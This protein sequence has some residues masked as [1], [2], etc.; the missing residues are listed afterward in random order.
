MEASKLNYLAPSTT[1]DIQCPFRFW[2]SVNSHYEWFCELR[3]I[4]SLTD[5]EDLVF[6]TPCSCKNNKECGFYREHLTESDM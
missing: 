6:I 5:L 1:R 4:D 3:P 2:Q